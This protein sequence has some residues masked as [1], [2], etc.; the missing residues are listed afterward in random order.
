MG[1]GRYFKLDMCITCS[2]YPKGITA[3]YRTPALSKYEIDY[4]LTTF[5][6]YYQQRR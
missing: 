4:H 2:M 3:H 1:S 5:H 6:A